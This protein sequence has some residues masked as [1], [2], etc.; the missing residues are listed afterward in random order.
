MSHPTLA[1]A[2]RMLSKLVRQSTSTT[3]TSSRRIVIDIARVDVLMID[4]NGG[5]VRPFVATAID[6]ESRC[7]IGSVMSPEPPSI[8]TMCRCIPMAPLSHKSRRRRRRAHV[9]STR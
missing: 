5:T 6:W 1:N 2:E 9:R 4:D 3:L 8:E 7:I